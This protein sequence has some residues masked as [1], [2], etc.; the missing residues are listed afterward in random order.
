MNKTAL[1]TGGTRGLG[2]AVVKRLASDG[3]FVYFNYIHNAERANQVVEELGPDKAAAIQCDVGDMEAVRAMMQ[4][5]YAASDHKLDVLVNNAGITRDK[6]LFKMG[7]D[8]WQQVID[9]NLTGVFNV[10]RCAVFEFLK[11]RSG[12]IINMSSV[13]GLY[14][15]EGQTNYAASK[16]GIIGFSKA[17]AREVSPRGVR[18]NV[19]AP[20]LIE[21]EM[22]EALEE[23]RVDQLM[24]RV[25]MGRFG[26]IDEVASV[27]SFLAGDGAS[28]ITGQ[29]IGVDGGFH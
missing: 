17:L 26:K 9:T 25:L 29:V 6:P 2:Y 27:V 14:G 18:V 11:K 16:A 4:Q 12:C 13:T 19:V 10:C 21:T 22:T 1:V 7:E 8:E 5:I 24:G 3:F 20:G 15:N 28:Y 23:K